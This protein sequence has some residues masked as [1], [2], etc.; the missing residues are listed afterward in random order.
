MAPREEWAQLHRPG[1]PP[2]LRRL[3]ML[4]PGAE[5]L[6]SDRGSGFL[7]AVHKSSAEAAAPARWSPSASARLE[8]DRA[9]P[10]ALGHPAVLR[11]SQQ[12]AGPHRVL[13]SSDALRGP[14]WTLVAALSIAPSMVWPM[15]SPMANRPRLPQ[16]QAQEV[17]H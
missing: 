14:P 16:E 15:T 8:K 13:R 12:A 9:R 3:L 1:P 6:A 4:L 2:A 10:Q 7:K 5:A 17:F 11:T